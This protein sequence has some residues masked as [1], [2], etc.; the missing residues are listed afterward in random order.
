MRGL[1]TLTVG[2]TFLILPGPLGADDDPPPGALLRLGTSRLR[3]DGEIVAVAFA[4]DGKAVLAARGNAVRRWGVATGKQSGPPLVAG[5]AIIALAVGRG[6]DGRP[7]VAAASWTSVRLW[8]LEAGKPLRDLA[9]GEGLNEFLALAPDGKTLLTSM[10]RGGLV[11]WDTATGKRLRRLDAPPELVS[12]DFSPDGTTFAAGC[13][14]G[15]IRLWEMSTG[16]EVASWTAHGNFCD[17]IAF[18]PDGKAVMSS[19]PDGAIRYWDVA[20]RRERRRFGKHPDWLKRAVLSPDGATLAASTSIWT[21]RLIDLGGKSP[22]REFGRGGSIV[23]WSLAFSPDGKVLAVAIDSTV[24]L[25]D[26]A[27]GKE[28]HPAEGHRGAVTAIDWS[29]DGRRV[30][31]AGRDRGVCIWDLATRRAVRT[32]DTGEVAVHWVGFAA[33][34]KRLAAGDL[35]VAS[36]WELATGRLLGEPSPLARGYASG[37]VFLPESGAVAAMLH[38]GLTVCDPATG[39]EQRR[40]QGEGDPAVLALAASPHGDVLAALGEDDRARTWDAL[41]WKPG[42]T[43]GVGKFLHGGGD[44]DMPEYAGALSPGGRWAAWWSASE[45]SV[46]VWEVASG[47]QCLEF[48]TPWGRPQRLAYSPDGRWLLGGTASEAW[49]WDAATGE[50]R[51]K[52]RCSGGHGSAA[53]FAPDGKALAVGQG[54]G[55]IL[56]WPAPAPKALPKLPAPEVAK[57]WEDLGAGAKQALRAVARLADTPAQAVPLLR[58]RLRPATLD[59][60][61][62]AKLI[63]ELGAGRY[64][65]R[66]KA[67]RDLEKLGAAVVPPLAAALAKAP[68]EETRR[69]IGRLLARLDG[70]EAPEHLRALRALAVLEQ[71]GTAE[72]RAALEELARVWAGSWRAGEV[73]AVLRRLGRRGATP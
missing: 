64:A 16:K 43:F 70:P 13:R 26:V 65:I 29:P 54:D 35:R 4:P 27:T 58:E 69:R 30:A 71:A 5:S 12:G 44:K 57:L 55:T 18:T 28:L 10:K 59:E 45:Q 6:P 15:K 32:L 23:P 42:R 9:A 46:C 41:T 25:W 21:I 60:K 31:S 47:A 22:D 11:L 20:T 56:L 73:S 1:G 7:L 61:Q 53:A 38:P 67:E 24:E 63:E 52:F 33:D 17:R 34:G 40:L 49:V 2:V 36:L 8:D 51:G 68:S 3:H 19:S 48:S 39:K 37:P 62:V 14:E 50:G 72:A 66:E